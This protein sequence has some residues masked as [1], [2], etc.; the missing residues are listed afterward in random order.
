VGGIG[1]HSCTFEEV[2]KELVSF[3]VFGKIYVE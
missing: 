1:R 2:L 3:F